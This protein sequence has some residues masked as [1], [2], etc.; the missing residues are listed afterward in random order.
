[1]PCPNQRENLALEYVGIQSPHQLGNLSCIA[2]RVHGFLVIT[3]GILEKENVTDHEKFFPSVFCYA[4]CFFRLMPFRD[5]E[6]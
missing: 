5:T 2:V 4:F 1:M 6:F 3:P